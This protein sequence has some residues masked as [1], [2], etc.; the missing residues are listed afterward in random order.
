M[1]KMSEN[2]CTRRAYIKN[3]H[4]NLAEITHQISEL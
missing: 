3:T 4:T 1:I 2:I